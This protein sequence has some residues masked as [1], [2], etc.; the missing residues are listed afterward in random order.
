VSVY[1][2]P[3]C[4]HVK[5]S[6]CCDFLH[7][8]L[9]CVLESGFSFHMSC[10]KEHNMLKL[11]FVSLGIIMTM[12]SFANDSN[13]ILIRDKVINLGKI[14]GEEVTPV[15]SSIKLVRDDKSPNN[16]VIKFDYHRLKK[17]CTDYAIEAKRKKAIKVNRCENVSVVADKSSDVQEKE[18]YSC[19]VKTF[20]AYDVLKRVCKKKGMILKNVTKKLRVL[21]VRSVALAPGATEEFTVTFKQK[22]IKSSK[23]TVSGAINSSSSLY[24]VNKLFNSVLEFKAK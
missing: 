21:F 4:L 22:K 5:Y 8:A 16:I 9:R 19:G 20:D 17:S 7:G 3:N 10:N 11:L 15:N 13:K 23:I 14:M 6:A 12:N 2:G 18:L 24:K 1:S